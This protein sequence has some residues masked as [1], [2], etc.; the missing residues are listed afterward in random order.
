VLRAFLRVFNLLDRPADL[1]SDPDVVQRVMA[2]YNDPE[3]RHLPLAGPGRDEL[4]KA[5]A[6]ASA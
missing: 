2:V 1:M 3:L 4:L 5:M 6:G